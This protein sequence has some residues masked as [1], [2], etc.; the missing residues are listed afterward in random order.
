MFIEEI[1]L[2]FSNLQVQSTLGCVGAPTLFSLFWNLFLLHSFLLRWFSQV[3]TSGLNKTN[4]NLKSTK[5]ILTNI[6]ATKRGVDPKRE[7]NNS[8]SLVERKITQAHYKWNEEEEIKMLYGSYKLSY[9]YKI[10][11]K[12]TRCEN[13]N[14]S[15]VMIHKLRGGVLSPR[16]GYESTLS[17]LGCP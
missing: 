14:K 16:R 1:F 9:V 5:Q 2:H 12:I 3:V 17:L 7:I 10:E 8:T 15:C 4:P 13:T 11:W 6:G